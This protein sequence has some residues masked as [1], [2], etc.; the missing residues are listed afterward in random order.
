MIR[1]ILKTEFQVY[2]D[3]IK[4]AYPGIDYE[5]KNGEDFKN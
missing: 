1:K 4:D 3:I 2:F 5:G